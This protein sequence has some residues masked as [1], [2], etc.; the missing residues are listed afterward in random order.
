MKKKI[1][2]FLS[3]FF[4]LFYKLRYGSRVWFGKKVILNHKLRIKGRGKLI[5]EEGVNLWAHE[6]PN[7]FFFYGKEAV[8]RLGKNG[9]YNGVSCHCQTSIEFGEGVLVGSTIL[10]DTDFHTFDDPDHVL[11]GNILSKPIVVQDHVWLAGQSVV[12]KGITVGQGS[13]V[14]FRAVVSKSVPAQVVVAGNP[15]RV[16]KQKDGHTSE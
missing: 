13:V 15:A 7:R 2:L 10:M 6:E 11:Y 5:V 16:V 3:Q 9:R 14:G 8:I 1:A 4:I 12:L